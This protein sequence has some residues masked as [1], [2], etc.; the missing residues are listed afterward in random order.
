MYLNLFLWGQLNPDIKSW[1]DINK[2]KI[3][4]QSWEYRNKNAKQNRSKP[5]LAIYTEDKTSNAKINILKMN[6]IYISKLKEKSI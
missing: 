2:R 6:E 5:N 3:L 4:R 1:Q